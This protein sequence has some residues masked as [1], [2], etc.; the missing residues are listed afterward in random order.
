[1]SAD[2]IDVRRFVGV[3]IAAHLDA[4]ATLRIEIFRAFPYLY[5]GDRSY[6]ERY[7][8]TYVRARGSIALIAFAPDGCVVGASTGAPLVAEPHETSAPFEATGE[9]IERIF[10]CGESLVRPAYRGRG[11]YRRFLEQR[12]TFARETGFAVCAFCAVDRPADHPARPHD[13]EPLDTIWEAFGYRKR[14]DLVARYAWKDC[15][16]VH[17]SEKPMIFWTKELARA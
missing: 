4:L 7:L 10:Y 8:R 12:E 16:D 3:E 9:A 15:G 13:Y 6:E 5:D 11:I 2:A 14:S 17:E 1:V